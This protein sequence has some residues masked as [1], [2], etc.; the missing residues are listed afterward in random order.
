MLRLA[1]AAKA[2]V[3]DADIDDLAASDHDGNG[4]ATHYGFRAGKFYER[5]NVK[6]Q[7]R[8]YKAKKSADRLRNIC[9]LDLET[10]PFDNKTQA[11]IFPFLAVV[12]SDQFPTITIWNEDWRE[13]VKDLTERLEALDESFTIYAH[14]GGRFDYMF[15]MH[16]LTGEAK[17][18]GPAIMSAKLGKH[19]IRDSLHI[20]PGSLR[21]ANRK[22]DID[23][24]LFRQGVRQR[25]QQEIT[26]YCVEDCV[27]LFEVLR[28][29]ID[30]HGMPLTI[31]QA[32]MKELKAEY[33]IKKLSEPVD[34]YMRQWFFGGRVETFATGHFKEPLKLYDVNSMYPSVM[35]H[36]EH[37]IGDE[38]FVNDYITKRTAFIHLKGI[39]DGA[40]VSRSPNGDLTSSVKRGEFWTTIHEYNAACELGKLREPMIIKTIDFCEWSDFSRFVLPRYHE[41]EKLKLQLDADPGNKS[42]FFKIKFLKDKLNNGYGKLAQNPR[43][44]NDHYLTAPGEKPPPDWQFRGVKIEA[45]RN[46]RD[47]QDLGLEDEKDAIE[48][49]ARLR[50]LPGEETD[51]FTVWSIP[52]TGWRFNNVATAASITGAARA[53]LMRAHAGAARAMYCD[54]DSL[55]CAA[56]GDTVE[57]DAARLGTWKCETEIT[58][59][60]VAGKKLYGY[61]T[62]DG[63]E[64]VRAKGQNGVTWEDLR[65][66]VGGAVIRKTMAAPTL[67]RDQGQ[68]YMTR[69][70]RM[71]SGGIGGN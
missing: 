9:V 69:E 32:A 34:R 61:R 24:K 10:D 66:I 64:K 41:R 38:F 42:L 7:R 65:A 40:L 26:D 71:T 17:F 13:L 62:P 12:Y 20:I 4:P 5:G 63:T 19:E 44:W 50:C 53:K 21:N 58:E 47:W 48:Y 46:K 45:Y 28:A 55:I 70:L 1:T 51:N 11:K 67:T 68:H 37:P 30:Q 33:D 49:Y 57:I 54:T 25:H 52:S 36:I 6:E 27:S 23:Y 35:A 16:H 18:K 14:N 31:G 43:R 59:L 2:S 56:L 3:V 60:I 8:R 29:F 39:N 22:L 15:L